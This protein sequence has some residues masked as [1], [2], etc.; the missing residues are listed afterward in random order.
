MEY[1]NQFGVVN[2]DHSAKL[3]LQETEK[4]VFDQKILANNSGAAAQLSLTPSDLDNL[5]FIHHEELA[6]KAEL[7]RVDSITGA[8]LSTK[9]HAANSDYSGIVYTYTARELCESASAS[10]AA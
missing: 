2:P 5:P 6:T 10:T 1:S 9:A 4:Q 3:Y 7:F 8:S